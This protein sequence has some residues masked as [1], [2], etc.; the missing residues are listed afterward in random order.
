ML[1]AEYVEMTS[2]VESQL[3]AQLKDL[4][5][6]LG[7]LHCTDVNA[8]RR[9]Y[10]S[11]S[12]HVKALDIESKHIITL[13]AQIDTQLLT[14]EYVSQEVGLIASVVSTVWV[15]DRGLRMMHVQASPLV[16]RAMVGAAAALVVWRLMR[17]S[18]RRLRQLLQNN[19]KTK[20]F[21]LEDWQAVQQRI[22]VMLALVDSHKLGG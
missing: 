17:S 22:Q 7:D 4:Q 5:Q 18:S 15:V 12:Q 6:K 21:L 11:L 9:A 13:M 16:T 10:T 20:A 2:T 14:P 3:R 8:L 19:A 1:H